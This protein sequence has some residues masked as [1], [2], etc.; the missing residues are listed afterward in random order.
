[1]RKQGIGAGLLIGRFVNVFSAAIL[2][3]DRVVRLH[4]DAAKRIAVA[5]EAIAKHA[6][7]CGK[8]E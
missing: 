3:L 4:G 5:E 2:F 6:E 8:S 7:I 1:M